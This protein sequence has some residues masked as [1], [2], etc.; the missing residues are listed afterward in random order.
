M[1]A[2]RCKTLQRGKGAKAS[3][4]QRTK[5]LLAVFFSRSVEKAQEK[6][7][8]LQRRD[9]EGDATGTAERGTCNVSDAAQ[10][11]TVIVGTGG[12]LAAVPR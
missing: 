1:H 10:A 3:K 5:L 7:D 8:L 9:R 12:Y 11:L 2:C 4:K 6:E